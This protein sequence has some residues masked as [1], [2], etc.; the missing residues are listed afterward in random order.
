LPSNWQI[1]TFNIG[2]VRCT[3][4]HKHQTTGWHEEEEFIKAF[5]D[6]GALLQVV[7]PNIRLTGNEYRPKRIEHFEVYLRA[8]FPEL[9]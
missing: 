9:Q 4:C 8:P 5:N 2:I 6:L 3:D 1:G 7:F